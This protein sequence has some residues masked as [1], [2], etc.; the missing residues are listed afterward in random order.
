MRAAGRRVRAVDRSDTFRAARLV[1]WGLQPTQRPSHDH[2]YRDLLVHYLEE[3]SFRQEVSDVARG[4]GL[5]VL[6]ASDLGIAL[7]PAGESVFAARPAD[8]RP[9]ASAD[10]RLLDGLVQIAIAATVFPRARDLQ[11]EARLVRQAVSVDELEDRLRAACDRLAEG[12]KGMPDPEAGDAAALYEAWRV[13]RG[14]PSARETADGRQTR[15]S[16]RGVIRFNLDR[17]VEFGCFRREQRSGKEVYAPTWRYQV[18]VRELAAITVFTEVRE[19]LNRLSTSLAHGQDLRD[20]GK[21]PR[22]GVPAA[23]DGGSVV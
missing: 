16:T 2:E 13:F 11:E 21:A 7:A 8:F 1:Q 6:D 9:G 20:G 15:S 10:D 5:D 17:L 22:E 23:G 12:A 18:Q 4:L 3:P 14:R 19:M